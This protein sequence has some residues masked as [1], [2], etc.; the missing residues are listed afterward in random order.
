MTT[1]FQTHSKESCHTFTQCSVMLEQKLSSRFKLHSMP[2]F[3]RWHV[4]IIKGKKSV[5]FI[6]A[7]IACQRLTHTIVSTTSYL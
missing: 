5:I 6:K 4:V 2:A 3:Y 1:L 7:D